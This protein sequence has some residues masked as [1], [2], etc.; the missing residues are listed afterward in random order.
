MIRLIILVFAA[1]IF[2]SSCSPSLVKLVN[3]KRYDELEKQILH[4]TDD[5]IN[6]KS[7]GKTPLIVAV[8]NN[9][10]EGVELLLRNGAD[11]NDRSIGE[12]EL[13]VAMEDYGG[14]IQ[15]IIEFVDVS[16]NSS[17]G[18]PAL[19]FAIRN[20]NPIILKLL[21]KNGA[22]PNF[23]Y[24]YDSYYEQISECGYG[25]KYIEGTP[26]IDALN[27]KSSDMARM[28]IEHGADVNLNDSKG[29]TPIVFAMKNELDLNLINL[30]LSKG[31]SV[32][33]INY[34]TYKMVKL[35]CGIFRKPPLR[36]YYETTLVENAKDFNKELQKVFRNAYDRQ[37][38]KTP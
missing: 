7:T 1:L 13:L 30:L 37:L 17:Y 31:A 2:C 34:E 19:V 32:I 11:V 29:N 24:Y 9:Y 6:D 25:Q 23:K 36:V 35:E 33:N 27:R 21:L 18:L 4:R 22:N 10:I 5:H 16:T 14:P 12:T 20:E 3:E 15:R 8:E 28:L 26:L 38:L